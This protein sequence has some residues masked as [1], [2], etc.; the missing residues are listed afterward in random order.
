MYLNAIAEIETRG[1]STI[2]LLKLMSPPWTE[3]GAIM[4]RLV[5]GCDAICTNH[6]SV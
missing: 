3:M 6:F 2:Y 4:G 5:V 1:A